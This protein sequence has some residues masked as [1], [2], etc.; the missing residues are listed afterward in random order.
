MEKENWSYFTYIISKYQYLGIKIPFTFIKNQKNSV[1][2]SC[3]EIWIDFILPL[4]YTQNYKD[5]TNKGSMFMSAKEKKAVTF[6]LETLERFL[7]YLKR[8]DRSDA[9]I[10][11]YAADLKA[12]YNFLPENK[13]LERDSLPKWRDHLISRELAA[14]TVNTRIAACN[15]FLSYLKRKDW[16][17]SPI[18]LEET[19]SGPG[20]TR[21]EYHTLLMTARQSNQ[22]SLYFM[23]KA[24]CCLGL[25]VSELPFLTV[26]AL[27]SGRVS[28]VTK[29]RLRN[30][31]VPEV[32]RQEFL[33]YALRA[34][35][36]SGSLFKS[37]AGEVLTRSYI[38]KKISELCTLAGIEAAKCTPKMLQDIYF[39]TYSDI[40]SSSSSLIDREY[41]KILEEE[42][43]LVGW[44]NLAV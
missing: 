34:N 22:E 26:D 21:K 15:S 19:Y 8:K 25:S 37:P 33:N 27:V 4:G 2:Y 1:L 38:V 39:Q 6:S 13:L 30:V 31:Y 35:I 29:S 9:T 43:A 10:R 23:I 7:L 20:I 44:D 3:S 5:I 11:K 24:F 18:A 36:N 16:Q 28:V 40:R 17:V 42:D 12:F 32:L 41:S 14:R